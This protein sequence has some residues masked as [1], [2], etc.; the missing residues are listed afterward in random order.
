VRIRK[1]LTDINEKLRE[2]EL[3]ND[4]NLITELTMEKNTLKS[5][6]QKI[7][8]LRRGKSSL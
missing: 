8:L 2:A 4:E 1:Q 5:E 6:E 3:E 7:T